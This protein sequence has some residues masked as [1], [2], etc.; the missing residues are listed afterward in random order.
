MPFFWP[1]RS[2]CRNS[3]ADDD[4]MSLNHLECEHIL[5]PEAA[6][7][8]NTMTPL[9]LRA[10]WT[11]GRTD[12]MAHRTT[13][14]S[15]QSSK[16]TGRLSV[17]RRRRQGRTKVCSPASTP[18]PT[19]PYGAPRT[20][21]LGCGPPTMDATQ[22]RTHNPGRAGLGTC[23]RAGRAVVSRA[24]HMVPKDASW[25][26][27]CNGCA[28]PST[29]GQLDCVC[30]RVLSDGTELGRPSKKNPMSSVPPGRAEGRGWHHDLP[31][32]MFPGRHLALA[33]P[34]PQPVGED[35]PTVAEVVFTGEN[36]T[37]ESSCIPKWQGA[38]WIV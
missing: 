34:P 8:P 21:R 1:L 33:F 15:S 14:R 37:P 13:H 2:C 6:S 25:E 18:N 9:R 16:K 38:A 11:D 24:G 29:A 4:D 26:R 7:L 20:Q 10:E 30:A 31:K 12:G 23:G 3:T 27:G 28:A 19:K 22:F 17:S 32:S 36:A 5:T 35:I